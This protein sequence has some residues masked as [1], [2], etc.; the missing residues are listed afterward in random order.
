MFRSRLY[1]TSAGVT[2][3]PS[4][5][6]TPDRSV[7]TIVVGE[8]FAT[9]A[10]PGSTEPSGAWRSSDSHINETAVESGKPSVKMGSSDITSRLVAQTTEDTGLVPAG[11]MAVRPLVGETSPGDEFADRPQA[12]A[13]AHTA[14]AMIIHR[15]G[16]LFTCA[17]PPHIR[18]RISI[19]NWPPPLRP[20]LSQMWR[21]VITLRPISPAATGHP[22]LPHLR[23]FAGKLTRCSVAA[24]DLIWDFG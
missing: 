5:N 12:A 3:W 19:T 18:L 10:R 21:P 24:L 13:S 22:Y 1:T 16:H 15:R 14:A 20:V 7:N 2:G 23:P 11:V 8:G 6:L 4:Q 9:V 17:P